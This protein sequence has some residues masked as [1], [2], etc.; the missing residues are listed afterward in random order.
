VLAIRAVRAAGL[1]DGAPRVGSR[2][3]GDDSFPLRGCVGE[4]DLKKINNIFFVLKINRVL[5]LID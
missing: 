2:V 4:S 1:V 5:R 3:A